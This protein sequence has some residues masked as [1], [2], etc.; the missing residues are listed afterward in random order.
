MTQTA[1]RGF[2]DDEATVVRPARNPTVL[3]AGGPDA[4]VQAACRVAERESR[5]INVEAC[6]A[7][8]IAT[9]AARSRP[10]ALIL[11]ADLFAFDRDEFVALARDVQADL[12]VVPTTGA[13]ETFFEQALQPSLRAA[14]RRFRTSAQSGTIRR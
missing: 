9:L 7:A 3:V 12:V 14:F 10:F 11:S 13:T 1:L 5:A 2:A 8:S 6:A 4:L